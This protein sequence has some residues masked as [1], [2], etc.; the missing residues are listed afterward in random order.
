M[1]GRRRGRPE[2]PRLS[3]DAVF[4]SGSELLL[5]ERGH[6]PF[7]GRWALPGGFVELDESCEQA[8]LRELEEETGLRGRVRSLLGVYSAPGRD[9][10]GPTASA[11]Y[12]IAG[13]RG[14]PRGGDDAR[15]ARWWPLRALP[16]LAFDHDQVVADARASWARS[17]RRRRRP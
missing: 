3:V 15:N 2:T 10:R 14:R 11:V 1:G 13:R 7:A 8:V 6:P 5:V 9:P 4:R 17:S 12:L 16:P